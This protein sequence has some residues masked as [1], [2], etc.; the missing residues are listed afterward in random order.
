MVNG[1]SAVLSINI[2]NYNQGHSRDNSEEAIDGDTF[3]ILSLL[4]L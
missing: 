1:L 2:N 3:S 4:G